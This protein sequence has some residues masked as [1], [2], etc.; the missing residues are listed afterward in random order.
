MTSKDPYQI[1]GV[2]R[3][4]DQDE[5]KRV[6]RRLAKEHHPDRNPG[7]KSAEQRFKEIQAAYEVI[8]D[9]SHRAQYDRFGS[10]GP[11]PEFHAW[12]SAGQPFAEDLNVDFGSLGDLTSIFEQFFQRGGPRRPQRRTTRKARPRGADI[13]HLVELSFDE[14]VNGTR[15]EIV[16][17]NSSRNVKPER[18][19]F[20]VPAGVND[21]QRIRVKGKGQ[22]GPG[23]RGDLMIRCHVRPHP[24]FR[25]EGL[26]LLLDLPL[27]FSEAALGAKVEIPTLDGP[28]V[29]TI[30]PGT[31]GGTK[32]RLQKRGIRD[33]RSE[34]RGDLYAV[35]RILT[36]TELSPRA[37]ELFEELEHELRQQPRANWTK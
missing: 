21:G 27:T 34:Q 32:L 10:G 26:D 18:I 36:P 35:V 6:Y 17:T 33:G 13:E 25:R 37:H 8:G 3:Q 30:P 5:I 2:S 9:P 24:L 22:D 20:R 23:G 28:M 15:C 31:G 4:A 11:A 7:N 16:L 12:R 1:L 14:A 19:E 29:V